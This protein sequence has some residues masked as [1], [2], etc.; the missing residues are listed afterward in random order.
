MVERLVIVNA[1]DWKLYDDIRWHWF[2][3]ATV[4][5]ITDRR[6]RERRQRT[7]SHGPERRRSER[8]RHS[9]TAAL[10]TERREPR[11]NQILH[12]SGLQAAYP[13]DAI[14]AACFRG[15]ESGGE[16]RFG[17]RP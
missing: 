11:G 8:R 7:D 9:I 2:G 4:K 5:V 13:R 16:H 6:R 15:T 17:V 12:G 1:S 14:G 10:R 3:D